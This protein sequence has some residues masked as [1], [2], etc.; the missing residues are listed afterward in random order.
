MTQMFGPWIGTSSMDETLLIY[1]WGSSSVGDLIHRFPFDPRMKVFDPW[2][3]V[4]AA[5]VHQLGLFKSQSSSL[6]RGC[7]SGLNSCCRL[8]VF[9]LEYGFSRWGRCCMNWLWDE[10]V[11]ETFLRWVTLLV[12][13]RWEEAPWVVWSVSLDSSWC[14]IVLV[15]AE[16][17]P[18]L[19]SQIRFRLA[20]I[21]LGRTYNLLSQPKVSRFRHQSHC[22]RAMLKARQQEP[23]LHVSGILS[24][25]ADLPWL[26]L[27]YPSPRASPSSSNEY[28]LWFYINHLQKPAFEEDRISIDPEHSA[29]LHL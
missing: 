1:E 11:L 29:G 17:L 15:L 13:R 26:A 3:G 5:G 6:I 4:S 20:R 16:P 7:W 22:L 24:L 21:R 14:F 9:N 19:F 27:S 18:G 8:K 25:R 12:D 23:E 28:T 10:L 2:M